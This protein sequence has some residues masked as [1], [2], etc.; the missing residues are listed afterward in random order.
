MGGSS[1]N[2]YP[3][4][5]GYESDSDVWFTH[6]ETNN[7]A[8]EE[9]IF[10]P[11]PTKLRNQTMPSSSIRT[12]MENQ[13]TGFTALSLDTKLL[14]YKNERDL[15]A[16]RTLSL[17]ESI[18]KETNKRTFNRLRNFVGSFD[19]LNDVSLDYVSTLRN[20]AFME[21]NADE[22]FSELMASSNV[23]DCHSS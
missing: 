6:H 12:S 22:K 1:N 4:L 8:H 9:D 15:A 14:L 3:S 21:K 13:C 2:N 17:T 10:L 5:N 20:L 11:S 18:L 16:Q 19:S 23:E 7:F